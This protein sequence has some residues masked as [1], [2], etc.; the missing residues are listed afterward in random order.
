M[1]II[2][3]SVYVYDANNLSAQPTKLTAFDGATYDLFGRSVAAD[4]D[5]IFVGAEGKQFNTGAVYVYDANNLSATPTKLTAF[6]GAT[7]DNFGSSIATTANKIFVGA[8]GAND[9]GNNSGA[10]YVYDANNL[11]ATPTKL[12]AFDGAASDNFGI[13]VAATADKIIVAAWGDESRTGAV[14]VYDANNLSA[15]PT[16]LTAFDGATSDFFGYSGCC[17]F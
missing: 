3:G 15:Q 4:G 9:N 7:G 10:V 2:S 14:Y 17:Y 16:K 1:D 12:T 13:S 5:K 8:Y 11:S 6:D